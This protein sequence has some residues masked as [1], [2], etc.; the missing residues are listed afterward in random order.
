MGDNRTPYEGGSYTQTGRLYSGSEVSPLTALFESKTEADKL[1]RLE[2]ERR[3]DVY[4]DD[5]EGILKAR[6]MDIFAPENAREIQK[7]AD[8]T[9]NP[10]KRIINEVSTLYCPMP[11]WEFEEGTDGELWHEIL[12]DAHAELVMPR[13]NRYVNL[14]N[15][16]VLYVAPVGDRLRFHA[17]PSSEV[18]AWEDPHD[19]VLPM[20]IMV[21]S[22]M[23]N[24]NNQ[25]PHWHYWSR[26]PEA[27]V[28]KL[29]DYKGRVLEHVENPYRDEFGRPVLPA[30]IYHRELPSFG[31][32]DCTSGNDL[33]EATVLIGLLETWINHLIKTDSVRQ[34]YASGL[35]DVNAATV[36]GPNS[37]LT[38]RSPDGSPVNVG[39]FT[40]QA[41]WTGLSAVIMR[42]INNVLTN[43]GMSMQDFQV[44]GDAQS[45]FALRVRKEGLIEMRE[46]QAP[47]YKA[48]DKELYRVVS[49]VWN[50]ERT[51]RESDITG[52]EL[53]WRSVARPRVHYAEFQTT[54]T[55]Q[56]RQ[57]ELE[58]A[59]VRI[60]M[61]LESPLTVY[62][63]ENPGTSKEQAL[64]AIQENKADTRAV[65]AIMGAPIEGA[66]QAAVTPPPGSQP[67]LAGT[68]AQVMA[69]RAAERERAA[70]GG[71]EGGQQ[72][73]G[74]S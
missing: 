40:S 5:W 58:L 41:D 71:D 38:F 64:K 46:R 35:L 39:E 2:A 19:P 59:K 16:A 54:L 48:W 31:I 53:P 72:Q 50:F 68:L 42:K 47:V 15:E 7:V 70:Q 8:T 21:R 44:S 30:V 3:L 67:D 51:N 52:P 34:K 37:V 55:V 69:R 10:L 32:W 25:P 11:T 60:E 4:E 43:Y 63:Q 20:A 49:A 13:L 9:N 18:I 73:G 1:R 26:D 74:E 17:V 24:T 65:K 45:G 22:T 28:Y 12:E 23:A 57:A 62:M 61:G 27:P 36:G 6:I 56:E 66:E 14:L 33:F 29:L